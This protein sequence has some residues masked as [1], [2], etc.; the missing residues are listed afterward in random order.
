MKQYE[1]QL[2][3]FTGDVPAGLAALNELGKLGWHVVTPFTAI[4]PNAF[5]GM[6]ANIIGVMIEREVIITEVP[7]IFR[8]GLDQCDI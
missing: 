6:T 8:S 3:S 1:Y 7:E 2:V 4:V 5:G